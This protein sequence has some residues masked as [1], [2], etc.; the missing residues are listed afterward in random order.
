MGCT[1]GWRGR[2]AL[3]LCAL[4]AFAAALPAQATAADGWVP[5]Q[6][7]VALQVGHWRIDELPEDQAR[8]RGQTGGS[9]GGFREVDINL[10]VAERAAAILERHGV[11]VDILPATVPRGY[12]ADAFIAIHCDASSDLTISGFKLARYRDSAR[13]TH[14]DAL[15]AALRARYDE[16]TGLRWDDNITRAMSGYYAYNQRRYQTVIS[17]RTPSA[18]F[19]LGFLTNPG[20][21]ALLVG[22]QDR[23]ATALAYGVLDYLALAPSLGVRQFAGTGTLAP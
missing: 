4:L 10:A 12:A 16:A 21:R 22:D 9:G 7:R 2:A 11:A 13:P 19:E 20:D 18:I 3:L 5:P 8:L 1:G 15:I 14:D 17:P 23:V 6:Q